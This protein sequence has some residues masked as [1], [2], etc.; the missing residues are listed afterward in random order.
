MVAALGGAAAAQPEPAPAPAPEP[1]PDPE[2]AADAPTSTVTLGGYLQPQGLYRQDDERAPSDE[3]GFKVR[4]ARLAALGKTTSAGLD[5]SA[6]VEAELTPEFQLL[7][8]YVTVARV[9]PAEVRVALD[10]GQVKAPISR[11]ELM[12]DANLAFVDKA[13]FASLAPSRQIGAR[14]AV[15]AP[16]GPVWAELT[17]GVFNGEGRNQ[18]ENVDENFLYT[19][20]L[21]VGYGGRG[22]ALMESDLDGA[23]FVVVG[24]SVGRNILSSGDAS[25]KL[26]YNGVDVAAGAKGV[27]VGFEYLLVKHFITGSEL[28]D[29]HT[30]GFEAHATYLLPFTLCGG[31]RLEV[32][33]RLEEVDR[34]DTI[35]IEMVGDP[36]Q[37]L[38]LYSGAVSYYLRGHSLKAQ[39]TYSHVQEVEDVDRTGRDATY[40]NDL[41]QLQ[42]TYRLE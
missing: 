6:F 29:Y 33:A 21:A 23:T 12:S 36:N 37:S 10:A 25:E 11:Q 22:R 38:R 13:L 24:G 27:S 35:P 1:A 2:L 26:I 19:G 41:V 30:N 15:G 34:N 28:P 14:A 20:R 17:G 3:D 4:R 7:D 5:L 31:G 18:V 32:G 8:A 40:P 39:L 42:L 9:L 16:V